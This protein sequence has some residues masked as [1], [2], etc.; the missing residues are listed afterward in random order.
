MRIFFILLKKEIKEMLTIPLIVSLVAVLFVF[1]MIGSVV[2]KQNKTSAARNNVV[3]LDFDKSGLSKRIIKSLTDGE[4]IVKDASSGNLLDAFSNHEYE[5]ESFFMVIPKGL[6]RDFNLEKKHTIEIYARFNKNLSGYSSSYSASK[7][8]KG[9]ERI[10]KDLGVH[11]IEKKFPLANVEFIKN[12]VLMEEFVVIGDS[13]ARVSVKRVL[14][15]VHSQTYFFPIAV[16]FLVFMAAQMIMTAVA[17]E[18][19]NKTLETL[20]SSPI[21]RRILVISKLSAAAIVAALLSGGYMF[22]MRSFMSGI[23]GQKTA[24]IALSAQDAFV[25]LGLIMGPADYLMIGVSLLFCILC[26]LVIALIL[27]VLSE[28]VKSVGATMTPLMMLIMIS[29]LLPMFIDIGRA[30]FVVKL[31]LY[32]IPFTHAFIAPQNI[33]AHNHAAVMW[34]IVY[35]AVIF[36]I[37]VTIAGKIF[38][39][40]ALLTFKLRFGKSK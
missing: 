32:S 35:Q 17:G 26:A 38:S 40:E 21:D 6:E 20:L 27:G 13:I 1:Y 31:L 16:F 19:E 9:I 30:S 15:F 22:G 39:G 10:N 28:D 7:I 24:G 2:G 3:V 37:F 18:K 4:Y 25:K 29:Y 33:L 11:I 5:E 36:A 12:P 23:M 34:G 14:L 8:R